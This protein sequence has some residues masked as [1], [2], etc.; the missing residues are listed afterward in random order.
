MF[1][2]KEI[3]GVL[4]N[5]IGEKDQQFYHSYKDKLSLPEK[6]STGKLE[7]SFFRRCMERE[8]L[9]NAHMIV[10]NDNHNRN[11]NKYLPSDHLNRSPLIYTA[12]FE[13]SMCILGNHHEPI[14]QLIDPKSCALPPLHKIDVTS[15]SIQEYQKEIKLNI[16]PEGSCVQSSQ[17]NSHNAI[18][19]SNKDIK[20]EI[21]KYVHQSND[22]HGTVETIEVSSSDDARCAVCCI[23]DSDD[24]NPIVFC[25]GPC[26]LCVHQDCYGLECIPDGDFYC[27]GC[28]ER[29]Q[30]RH[31][32]A[33]EVDMTMA[34]VCVLCQQAD[35]MMKRSTCRQW[36]HPI[37]VSYTAELTVDRRMRANNLQDLDR[38]R[39]ELCCNECGGTGGA[40]VQCHNDSCLEGVHPY[41]AQRSG[42]KMVIR[43]VWDDSRR[44]DI[45]RCE[46]YCKHH[47]SNVSQTNVFSEL[48]GTHNGVGRIVSQQH[49]ND[50][51]NDDNKR[52]GDGDSS[53]SECTENSFH[54]WVPP[55]VPDTNENEELSQDSFRSLPDTRD[56]YYNGFPYESDSDVNETELEP[57]MSSMPP[58]PSRCSKGYSPFDNSCQDSNGVVNNSENDK[59]S[60][61]G[62]EVSTQPLS[63]D[64]DNDS[65]SEQSAEQSMEVSSSDDA[66]CAVCCIPDSDDSNPIVFCDGPCGLCV[67]QDC[68]GLECIPDGDFYCEG[69]EE[70]RQHCHNGATEV[71][72]T[73]A[74]VCVLC[75]QADGMM[76]RSTCRQWVHPIC[77]SY[78]AELTVDRRMRA[79]NLQ[80]LDRE[81]SELCCNECGG[82]GGA[83][84]QCH[85]DSCLEGVH[86]YC[87]QR[88][89]WK[90][91][92]RE[93]WDDSRRKDRQRCEIYCPVHSVTF[94]RKGILF[95]TDT[96]DRGR[97]SAPIVTAPHITTTP[98]TITRLE[99]K[100][101]DIENI[102]CCTDSGWKE[103]PYSTQK[104]TRLN[105][106]RKRKYTSTGCH[107]AGNSNNKTKVGNRKE[108]K[109]ISSSEKKQVMKLF[110]NDVGVSC[111]DSD[112]DEM[113]EEG[114]QAEDS[115]I[116]D[117]DY[118]QHS[119]D[120]PVQQMAMYH[121]LHRNFIDTP[122]PLTRPAFTWAEKEA[123]G[124]RRENKPM[125]L[126]ALYPSSRGPESWK[127]PNR[128]TPI[129][130][131][132]QRQ[133]QV[134]IDSLLI[135][136]KHNL[137]DS[138]PF[139]WTNLLNLS[140]YSL[141]VIT[142]PHL[143]HYSSFKLK[144]VNRPPR[145]TKGEKIQRSH[146]Y[147]STNAPP[148]PHLTQLKT[149]SF[150]DWY[151]IM[152]GMNLTLFPSNTTDGIKILNPKNFRTLLFLQSTQRPK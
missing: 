80:D 13:P 114:E 25:D 133:R 65:N 122:S 5:S 129:Q 103:S 127:D 2:S 139:E 6:C 43:E 120:D 28:E 20:Q 33:T 137:Q 40:V 24:S 151:I 91:V 148:H 97:A 134:W 83:V 17:H 131:P 116:N 85:N 16:I 75:Q 100:R 58:P 110:D 70:R 84:V 12:S 128:V 73:M 88:S 140:K 144:V 50:S 49:Q 142:T 149:S 18:E 11:M 141:N 48:G 90:I 36:V 107:E 78:T 124:R 10:N 67:H 130:K 53:G 68:Y 138:S 92:I 104:P 54:T 51:S 79:N 132:E 9:K 32:G 115:F 109:K 66:P 60:C 7:I 112:S 147:S 74:T 108:R 57:I 14:I 62:D 52:D 41:C 27:E 8:K 44:K 98:S 35:G 26:G 94:S 152:I 123:A 39:S 76:K 46:I 146:A 117:G 29:R 59:S 72:M 77:V 63:D 93:V 105:R 126:N 23:P 95:E 101:N 121:S 3:I 81:R 47:Y 69:C 89:G 19:K 106:L 111:S 135:S 136:P 55:T 56:E 37:C 61:I 45:Q 64:N 21:L 102:Q 38:E 30:R 99:R 22:E 145:N 96:S 34:T 1:L 15:T 86:P 113:S 31:N 71:D 125:R 87:A 82:T 119:D 4:P 143:T 118:T 42:W 150:L